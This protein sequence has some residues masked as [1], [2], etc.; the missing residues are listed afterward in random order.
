[1]PKGDG[2]IYTGVR[3]HEKIGGF[4]NHNIYLG[5]NTHFSEMATLGIPHSDKLKSAIHAKNRQPLN[6]NFNDQTPVLSFIDER[7]EKDRVFLKIDAQSDFIFDTKDPISSLLH[8][9]IELTVM[10]AR[11]GIV[12]YLLIHGNDL[13]NPRTNTAKPQLIMSGDDLIP[14]Y[15]GRAYKSY[16]DMMDEHYKAQFS[17]VDPQNIENLFKMNSD[18]IC[19]YMDGTTSEYLYYRTKLLNII[20]KP[21]IPNI[22]WWKRHSLWKNLNEITKS[23]FDTKRESIH[24]VEQNTVK[25]DRI[26]HFLRLCGIK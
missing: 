1:M 12:D 5:A 7:K 16:M 23:I 3:N 13:P 4:R 15:T 24:I 2:T 8:T 22:P 11:Q 10:G 26:V 18:I 21:N 20:L 6:Q 17:T 9:E 14:N 25:Y 19:T